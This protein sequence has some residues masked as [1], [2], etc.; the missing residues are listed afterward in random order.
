MDS[1]TAPPF[2]PPSPHRAALGGSGKIDRWIVGYLTISA[3]IFGIN[4]IA[5]Y[6][7]HSQ[8]GVQASA[9]L[10]AALV[11]IKTLVVPPPHGALTGRATMIL[12]LLLCLALFNSV[13]SWDPVESSLRWVLWFGLVICFYRVCGVSNGTWVEATIQRLPYLF[14]I[15]YVTILIVARYATDDDTV[16]SGYHLSGLYGNLILASGLFARKLWQRSLWSA[17]GLAAIFFSGAGGALFTIPIMFVPYILYSATSMPVKGIAIAGMLIFGGLFFFESQLFEQFLDIKLNITPAE[18]GS[19]NG[20]DRLE[21][22]KD[23]RL[24][25]VEYGFLLAEQHPLGTGLGHT[26]HDLIAEEMGVPHVHNG[27]LTMIIELGFPGFALVASLVLWIFSCIL[28]SRTIDKQVKAFYFTYFFTVFGRSLAENYTFFDLGNFFNIVFLMF[29]AYFF[30]YERSK[31]PVMPVPGRLVLGAN[32]RMP[33]PRWAMPPPGARPP[34]RSI[35]A[36]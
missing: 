27:T 3:I 31:Q 36:H 8:Y 13:V 23:M 17:V 35:P 4:H 19:Y 29:T 20:L 14:A 2:M 5:T 6:L 10:V 32:P 28:R 9:M 33:P 34:P 26:Y 12:G 21:R 7:Y 11:L 16:R 1:N 30:L 15:L 18:E 22:S 25:L 24:Q